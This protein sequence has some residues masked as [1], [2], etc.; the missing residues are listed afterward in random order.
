MQLQNLFLPLAHAN[1]NS[2]LII[3][4][5]SEWLIIHNADASTYLKIIQFNYNVARSFSIQCN[6]MWELD[7]WT[8]KNRERFFSRLTIKLKAICEILLNEGKKVRI[9]KNKTQIKEKLQNLKLEP[10]PAILLLFL[11][12]SCNEF[13]RLR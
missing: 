3:F 12:S 8:L 1:I 10:Q 9:R 13:F 2:K 5:L 6:V 7:K 11:I 4:S